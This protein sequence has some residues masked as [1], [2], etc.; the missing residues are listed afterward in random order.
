M[1]QI[2]IHSLA[3]NPAVKSRWSCQFVAQFIASCISGAAGLISLI[4]TAP[5]ICHVAAFDPA[6]EGFY[7][8]LVAGWFWSLGRMWSITVYGRNGG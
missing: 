6:L 3:T 8:A 1:A 5:V 7:F 4:L 2:E